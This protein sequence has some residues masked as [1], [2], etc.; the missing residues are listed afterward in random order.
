MRRRIVFSLLIAVFAAVF[1]LTGSTAL[2]GNPDND[3]RMDNAPFIPCQGLYVAGVGLDPATR[4][5]GGASYGTP[6]YTHV[7]ENDN[8]MCHHG[9]DPPGE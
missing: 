4:P 9:A 8:E 7:F 3:Q 5:T 2:A 6:G 1:A